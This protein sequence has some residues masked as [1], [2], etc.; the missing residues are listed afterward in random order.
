MFLVLVTGVVVAGA[1]GPVCARL[2]VSAAVSY[3]SGFTPDSALETVLATSLR[4][5]LMFCQ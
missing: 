4:A 1:T 3:L 5:Y 2:T